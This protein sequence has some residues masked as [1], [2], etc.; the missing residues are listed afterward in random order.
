M[1]GWALRKLKIIDPRKVAGH[2]WR[3]RFKDICRGAG[4]EKAIH[5]ALTGH[6]SGDVGDGYGLGYPLHTLGAAIGKLPA[7]L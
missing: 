5:D 1:L 6:S 4:I 3:H 2:S 7:P